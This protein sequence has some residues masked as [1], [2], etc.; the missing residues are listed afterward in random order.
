MDPTIVP[1]RSCKVVHVPLF[2][3]FPTRQCVADEG[4]SH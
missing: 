2:P 4:F 3:V 1:R